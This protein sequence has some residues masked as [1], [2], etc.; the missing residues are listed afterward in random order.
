MSM[1]GWYG[2]IEKVDELMRNGAWRM[3]HG[4]W[5]GNGEQQGEIN[6]APTSELGGGDE[7]IYAE[8]A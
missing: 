1:C 7:V 3:E 2:T 8:A 4:A 6:L 5:N